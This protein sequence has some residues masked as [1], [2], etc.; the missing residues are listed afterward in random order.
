MTR[1]EI[2]PGGDLM[3]IVDPTDYKPTDGKPADYKLAD[4]KPTD[5]KPTDGK[6]AGESRLVRPGR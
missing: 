1:P 5:Y 6:L 4:G 3:F 2:C